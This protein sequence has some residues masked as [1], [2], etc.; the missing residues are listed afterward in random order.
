MQIDKPQFSEEGGGKKNVN[1]LQDKCG[2]VTGQITVER[3]DFRSNTRMASAVANK[4]KAAATAAMLAAAAAA[5]SPKRGQAAGPSG[6]GGIDAP[7]PELTDDYLYD[8]ES[9][10]RYKDQPNITTL[11]LRSSRLFVLV[12]P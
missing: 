6:A 3:F 11:T 8:D 1:V 12:V 10:R 9:L 2:N 7:P 5:A 4:Q